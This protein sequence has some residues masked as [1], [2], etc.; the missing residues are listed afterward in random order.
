[1]NFYCKLV[2]NISYQTFIIW[3]SINLEEVEH[4]II[5]TEE[6]KKHIDRSL[7]L[8]LSDTWT[9]YQIIFVHLSSNMIW[10]F[11]AIPCIFLQKSSF[12][13]NKRHH[14]SQMINI[15]WTLAAYV[16]DWNNDKI[17]KK[18]LT[19]IQCQLGIFDSLCRKCTDQSTFE[20]Q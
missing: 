8:T 16:G 20:Y 9:R 7:V 10:F 2:S 12:F 19:D 1:M 11:V 13:F 17:R 18:Y 6:E 14:I 3:F 15:V 5:V 4:C